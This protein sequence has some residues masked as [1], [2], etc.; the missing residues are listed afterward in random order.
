MFLAASLSLV[1]LLA[2]LAAFPTLYYIKKA[3]TGNEPK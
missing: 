2:L 1:A 3:K